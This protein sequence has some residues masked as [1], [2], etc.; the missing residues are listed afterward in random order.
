MAREVQLH[1]LL[2]SPRA[3]VMAGV[4]HD[5]RDPNPAASNLAQ[6]GVFVALFGIGLST[7]VGTL[8]SPYVW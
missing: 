5:K 3:E 4:K 2:D 1:V 7:L 8:D 6:V